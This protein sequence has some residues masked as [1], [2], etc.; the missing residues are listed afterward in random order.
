MSLH[1]AITAHKTGNRHLACG[2]AG[3]SV[4]SLA[5]PSKNREAES[6]L[7]DNDIKGTMHRMPTSVGR[8]YI[9]PGIIDPLGRGGR[10]WL[11]SERP[12]AIRGYNGSL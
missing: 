7:G 2:L 1:V 11:K 5:V 9:N 3:W 8:G 4:R 10:C 12:A 6:G